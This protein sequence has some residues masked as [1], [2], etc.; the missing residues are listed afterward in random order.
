MGKSQASEQV[1][2]GSSHIT[3]FAEVQGSFGQCFQTQGLNFGWS[4]VELGVGLSDPGDPFQPGHSMILW[5]YDQS[6]Q[7]LFAML[8]VNK[9]NKQTNLS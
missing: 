1:P 6:T 9:T 3:K 2:Q 4:C 5:F 8:R 7:A